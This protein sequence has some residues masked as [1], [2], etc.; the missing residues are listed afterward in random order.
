MGTDPASLPPR[1]W[2]AGGHV[3]AAALPGPGPLLNRQ[4]FPGGQGGRQAKPKAISK[5][6]AGAME[7]MRSQR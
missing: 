5:P 6:G 2:E 1:P 4:D 3:E 7:E